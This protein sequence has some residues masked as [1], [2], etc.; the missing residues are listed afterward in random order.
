MVTVSET[1]EKEREEEKKTRRLHIPTSRG[2]DGKLGRRRKGRER[3]ERKA[4]KGRTT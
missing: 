1:G 3:R 2:E 4:K